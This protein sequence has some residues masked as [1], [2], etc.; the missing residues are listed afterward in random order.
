[1]KLTGSKD[2]KKYVGAHLRHIAATLKGKVV[3]DVPAG[4]GYSTEILL[5]T[6]AD[7]RPFDLFPEFFKVEGVECQSADMNQ[8]LPM[9]DASAD[10]VLFQ[11][12]IEHLQDQLHVLQEMNRILKPGGMLLLTTPNYSNLRAKLSYF[13]N[14]SE[15]YKLMPPNQV[16]S[17]WFG[18]NTSDDKDAHDSAGGSRY[19]FGHMFLI[20]IHRLRLLATLAGFR[21]RKI[22]HTRVNITSL[23]LLLLFYPFILLSSY[24]AYRRALR[25][26]TFVDET[27][28]KQIFR[29]SFLI[30]INPK[31]LI[32]SHLFVEFEK[33][34][35]LK[36][37]DESLNI[38]H[39]HSDADFQT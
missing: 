28:R 2:I 29:E 17:I 22:H 36:N 35:E 5:Q 21:I 3:V 20:G 30:M 38:Y 16:E 12:G 27:M 25:K 14:E 1:M 4:S 18:Q 34:H 39:K 8:A 23:F 15:I 13:L 11:E 31:I 26:N 6:G 32:D 19:Y 24:R 33:V 9:Q 37:I 10:V 7:V